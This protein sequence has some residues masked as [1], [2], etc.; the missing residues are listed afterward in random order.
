MTSEIAS[1][2]THAPVRTA[3]AGVQPTAT[4]KS[5][6]PA[7]SK[8][9]PIPKAEVNFDPERSNQHLK[10]AI[11]KLN[12]L[13]LSGGRG[14]NFTMDE[15]LGRPIVYVKNSQT[16]EIVRQ[17]PNEVIVQIAYNIEDLKGILHNKAS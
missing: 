14:L 9:T 8:I 11:S 5:N 2:A 16:G 6:D 15:K 17:I 1:L 10:E 3:V 4:A 7:P 12:E 13:M